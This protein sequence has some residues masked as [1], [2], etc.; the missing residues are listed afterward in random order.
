MEVTVFEMGLQVRVAADSGA[1][2]GFDEQRRIAVVEKASPVLV[3]GG[4]AWRV[5]GC[6]GARPLPQPDYPRPSRRGGAQAFR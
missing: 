1:S 4:E 5:G 3:T 6:F 2:A